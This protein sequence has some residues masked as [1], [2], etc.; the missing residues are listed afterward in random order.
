M[1]GWISVKY[2]PAVQE[3]WV[4]SPGREDPLEKGM[5]SALVLLLE[6]PKDRGAWQATVHGVAESQPWLTLIWKSWN[7][8]TSSLWSG[9]RLHCLLQPSCSPAPHQIPTQGLGVKT[10]PFSHHSSSPR[11]HHMH[12]LLLITPTPCPF[13]SS[14][15]FPGSTL[16]HPS[17][18]AEKAHLHLL[19]S[20]W[21][22]PKGS[23]SCFWRGSAVP[24]RGKVNGFPKIV[25]EPGPKPGSPGDRTGRPWQNL[26]ALMRSWC[27][28]NGDGRI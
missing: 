2:P 9:F 14:L 23:F 13:R 7:I 11:S 27:W 28:S 12:A 25:A 20:P 24:H 22:P 19:R 10:S 18:L 6:N 3:T 15:R 8:H 21:G 16:T 4:P 26:C 17:G 1:V 5:L